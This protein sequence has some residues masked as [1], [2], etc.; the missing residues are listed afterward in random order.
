MKQDMLMWLWSNCDTSMT[1]EKSLTAFLSL[2]GHTAVRIPS[3]ICDL[4]PIKKT[5]YSRPLYY[6]INCHNKL[7]HR[8][9]VYRRL[10]GILKPCREV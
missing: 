7:G 4:N 1:K 3:Y 9:N 2:H 5:C 10:E 8:P 6:E